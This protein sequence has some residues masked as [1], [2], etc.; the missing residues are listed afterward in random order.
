M[1]N[2]VQQRDAS[3]ASTGGVYIPP[4]A[5]RNGTLAEDRYT[6]DQLLLLFREQQE[7]QALSSG[8]PDLFASGWEPHIPNGASPWARRDEQAR[9]AQP[10]ADICWQQEGAVLPLGLMGMTDEEREVRGR[11]I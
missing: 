5:T 6:R 11:C 10:G 9:D 7:A 4:H 3:S 1:S 8:L 2:N